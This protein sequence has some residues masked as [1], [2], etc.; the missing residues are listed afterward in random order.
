MT[1]LPLIPGYGFKDPTQT[2]F[3]V[4]QQFDFKNGYP[5][6]RLCT[7]GIGQKPLD[8]ESV[9]YLKSPDFT[10]LNPTLMYGKVKRYRVPQFIPHFVRYDSKCL[11]FYAFF[12]QSVDNPMEQYRIR[13]VKIIYF[14]E[15][16]TITVLEPPVQNS[17]FVQGKL[18]RRSKVPKNA[19]GEFWHWKDFNIG[20]DIEFFGRVFHIVDCDKFTEEYLKS[21]GVEVNSPEQMP[22][23]PYLRDRQISDRPPSTKTPRSKPRHFLENDGGVLRFYAAWDN[24][25]SEFGDLRPFVICY[26]IADKTIEILEV[27]K[28]NDGYF[29]FPLLLKKTKLPKE[30]KNFPAE[31][32]AQPSEEVE[33][34]DLKYYSPEDLIVG[35]TICILGRR[36]IIYDADNFT[37]QYY[38]KVLNITQPERMEV[39]EK[40][41]EMPQRKIPPYT[42]FGTVED[43][44]QSCLS[45]RPR[46]PKKDVVRYI[47]NAKKFLRYTAK[48]DWVHPE[49]EIRQ[50]IFSYS[51]FDG[52]VGIHERALCNSGIVGGS[53]LKPMRIPKPGTDPNNPEYYSPSDFYIGAKI[54]V[55]S[56]KFI[57]TGADLFVYNYMQDHQ[58]KFP[59]TAIDNIRN[60][61]ASQGLLNENSQKNYAGRLPGESIQ[62][63]TGQDDM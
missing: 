55:F 57:I 46:S 62:K 13:N 38:E 42:G 47:L 6:P 21:Q 12:T 27:H 53:F 60:W 31:F 20:M 22:L 16:D 33:D 7:S 49:D 9:G 11:T 45:L 10:R 39:F 40:P 34:D 8:V 14:L 1:G 48:L 43:S 59:P 32:P 2:R 4:P 37:R 54:E 58:D 23:D 52:T 5:I 51:L 41:A 28:K 50:F 3:H 44:Y 29:P 56:H 18:I 61:L 63:Q 25:D 19:D 24:R 26:Y 30:L 17:G 36:F 15:D 35:N